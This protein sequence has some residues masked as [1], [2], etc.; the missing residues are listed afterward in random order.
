[1]MRFLFPQ[2]PIADRFRVGDRWQATNGLAYEVCR[3][4]SRDVVRLVPLQAGE[5][6]EHFGVLRVN[7]FRRLRWGGRL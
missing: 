5:R 3:G 7:G 4:L 2:P 1:M 6:I